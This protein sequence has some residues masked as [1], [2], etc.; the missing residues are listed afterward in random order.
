MDYS[1]SDDDV[2]QNWSEFLNNTKF[3]TLKDDGK[4]EQA[5]LFPGKTYSNKI[6]LNLIHSELKNIQR[7]LKD[8]TDKLSE[9]YTMISTLHAMSEITNKEMNKMIEFKEEMDEKLNRMKSNTDLKKD[10]NIMNESFVIVDD[11][12]KEEEPERELII[13]K[14]LDDVVCDG[15]RVDSN[16]SIVEEIPVIIDID[17][18]PIEEFFIEELPVKEIIID[19][20]NEESILEELP[21]V[22]LP[23]VEPPATELPAT[24]L[25]VTD[26]PVMEEIKYKTYKPYYNKENY[27]CNDNQTLLSENKLYIILSIMGD[28][29]SITIF[30]FEKKKIIN[31]IALGTYSFNINVSEKTE[32]IMYFNLQKRNGIYSF[33]N[34]GD[35][36]ETLEGDNILLDTLPKP[37]QLELN[38]DY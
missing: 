35:F 22:E 15:V 33:K 24:E 28:S 12:P 6:N 30:P 4:L 16:N 20:P 13:E 34:C 10:K 8:C 26:L 7:D 5:I 29:D 27:R 19:L 37:Y 23:A 9:L 1:E 32:G 25:P 18:L 31:R 2:L 17:K 14:L 36:Y 11:Q 38:I 3:E 21:A